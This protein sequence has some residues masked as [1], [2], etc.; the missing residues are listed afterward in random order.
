MIEID[1]ER[2][3]IPKN[4][5]CHQNQYF[6]HKYMDW[7]DDNN[8][9]A[10]E[11]NKIHLDYWS[12]KDGKFKSND[13]FNGFGVGKT[14][15]P[16]QSLAIKSMYSTFGLLMSNYKFKAENDAPNEMNVKQI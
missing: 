5:I 4:T 9:L 2:M 3:V 13:N 16:G 14:D 1:D 7:N 6:M 11:N 8:I 15:C 10:E 12:D